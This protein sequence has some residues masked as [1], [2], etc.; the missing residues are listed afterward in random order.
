MLPSVHFLDFTEGIDPGGDPDRFHVLWHLSVDRP[1]R[2]KSS[3][4]DAEPNQHEWGGILEGDLVVFP[5]LL[6]GAGEFESV[7][8]VGPKTTHLPTGEEGYEVEEEVLPLLTAGIERPE[9]PTLIVSMAEERGLS[10]REM[11]EG[12]FDEVLRSQPAVLTLL[13]LFGGYRAG[14]DEFWAD[15]PVARRRRPPSSSP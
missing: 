2:R 9:F 1:P 11:Y 6:S 10:L 8:F 12:P 13:D 5:S 7:R 15:V 3:P 14:Y 4:E